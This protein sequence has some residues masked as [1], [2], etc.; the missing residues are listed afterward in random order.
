MWI[1]SS[2]SARSRAAALNRY[3]PPAGRICSAVL[4]VFC[5]AL[6][7]DTWWPGLAATA[8]LLIVLSFGWRFPWWQLVRRIALLIPLLALTGLSLIGQPD[9]TERI[10]Q[11]G[12]KAVLS[13]WVMSMLIHVTPLD[14]LIEG[15]R[16]LRFPPIGIELL[17]FLIRY[18]SVLGEEWRRMQLARRARTYRQS[19]GAELRAVAQSL[20]CLFI[21]AY[22]RAERVHQAMLARGYRPR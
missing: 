19:R 18:F 8:F 6:L 21:R 20:G 9:W 16:A 5:I 17:T 10:F 12:A 7:P 1:E 13:L 3:F 14:D 22:E 11:L 15:L 4:W 2:L